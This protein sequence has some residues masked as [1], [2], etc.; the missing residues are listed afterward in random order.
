MELVLA[1]AD[2]KRARDRLTYAA[3]G[4]RA[5]AE[6]YLIREERLCAHPWARETMTVVAVARRRRRGA[7]VVRDLPHVLGGRRR[8]RRDLGGGERVHRAGAARA[9]PRAGDDGRAGGAGA[10]ERARRRRRCSATWRR[11]STSARGYVAR[12]A[13]DLLFPPAHGDPAR[14]VDTLVEAVG[15]VDLQPY[16]DDFACGRRRRSSTGTSSADAPTR[17]CWA[18]AGAAVGGRARRRRRGVLGGR[19]E[20]RA[21]DRAVAG[22]GARRTRRRR[23]CGRRANH[24][25]RGEV[26]RGAAVGAAVAVPGAGGSWRRSGQAGGVGA[27]DRADRGGGDGGDVDADS[28]GGVGVAE[29]VVC[30]G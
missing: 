27:D 21:A 10:R 9:R 30:G 1:N 8:A 12:P 14:G 28:A 26:A 4:E 22:R 15:E 29:G 6:Q 25:G 13:E 7:V 2:A 3:W 19:L 17:R 20:D 23:W 5:H 11:Q 16:V 24:G 18:R